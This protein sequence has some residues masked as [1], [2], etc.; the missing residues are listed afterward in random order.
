ML[1]EHSCLPF[2]ALHFD[3]ESC[4]FIA[5]K[6]RLLDRTIKKADVAEHPEVFHDVGLLSNAPS[7]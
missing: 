4:L 5:L 6:L 2:D 7:D 1:K 3:V